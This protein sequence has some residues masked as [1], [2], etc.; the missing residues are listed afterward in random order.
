MAAKAIVFAG[1]P[2]ETELQQNFAPQSLGFDHEVLRLL[3]SSFNSTSS[4]KPRPK[5]VS[6]SWRSLP[7]LSTHIHASLSGMSSAFYPDSWFPDVGPVAP[8]MALSSMSPSRRRIEDKHGNDTRRQDGPG[9]WDDC[10]QRDHQTFATQRVAE[11]TN[12]FLTV[13]NESA[14]LTSFRDVRA[15]HG[16]HN[17]HDG[18]SGLTGPAEQGAFLVTPLACIPPPDLVS[19]FSTAS[20]TVNLIVGIISIMP[21][22]NVPTRWGTRKVVELAVGDNTKAGFSITFWLTDSYRTMVA[23]LRCQDVVLIRNV[24]LAPFNNTVRGSSLRGNLTK[25]HLLFRNQCSHV[26]IRGCYHLADMTS[27][28]PAQ[29]QLKIARRVWS[30]VFNFAGPRFPSEENSAWRRSSTFGWE[31][32]PDDSQ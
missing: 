22:L 24:A 6:T 2:L 9:Q 10:D 25:V 7:S 27:S 32:P 17:D 11:G 31:D 12:N 16:Q 19:T 14:C 8:N 26:D 18:A 29:S 3:R 20:V 15:A 28:R 5:T 21:A 4:H 23:P 13:D 1:A 30:W